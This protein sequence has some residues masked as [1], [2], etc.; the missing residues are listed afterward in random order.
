MIK[1]Y[2]ILFVL[3]FSVLF[4]NAGNS[5]LLFSENFNYPNGT[6]LTSN[7]WTIKSGGTLNP[8]LVGTNNGLSYTGYANSGIGNAAIMQD[9]GQDVYRDFTPQITGG[10]PN[11]VNLYVSFLVNMTTP[12]TGD[13]F[14][15][16]QNNTAGNLLFH[17]RTYAKAVSGGWNIGLSK[18]YEGPVYGTNTLALNTTYLVVLRYTINPNSAFDDEIVAYVFTDPILP[19]SESLAAGVATEQIGPYT[20]NIDQTDAFIN[21]SRILLRQGSTSS[22]PDL[23]IDGI[24]VGNTWNDSPLPVELSSFNSNVNGRDIQLSWSTKTEKNSDKFV[25]Q[26]NNGSAWVEVGS[27]KA[28]VLS[29]SPKYYSFIDKKLQSGKYQYRLKMI[30]NDGTFQHSS[31]VEAVIQVPN[32]Y[33]LMQNYPNPFNP[34]TVINYSIPQDG[35]VTLK[36]FDI[37]GKEAAELVNENQKAGTYSVNF[38]ASRLSSGVYFYSLGSGSFTA[39]KKLML[40]K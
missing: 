16:L 21:L 39:V 27:V 8:I 17:L 29:N 30:D 31:I 34:S 15:A 3:L 1:T 4:T 28:S 23:V 38:D 22:S 20:I 10:N 40:I 7:G 2:T 13:F 35:K 36:V 6:A 9:T 14:L 11:I 32:E 19:A 5:Q 26:R 24:R 33:S 25:I 12:H 18:S 37:T